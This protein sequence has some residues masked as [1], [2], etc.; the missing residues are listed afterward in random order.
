M[1]SAL[2]RA[3]RISLCSAFYLIRA[4]ATDHASDWRRS[5]NRGTVDSSLGGWSHPK[6]FCSCYFRA[7]CVHEKP[8]LSRKLRTRPWL[9]HRRR[10]LAAGRSLRRVVSGHLFAGDARRIGDHGA[11]L[12][13]RFSELF[14]LGAYVFSE[15]H[16]VSQD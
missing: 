11:V 10:P 4:S 15:V 6:E 1:D 5:F 14:A 2:A 13:R 12:W 3:T 8:T 7:I 9:Y 16:C